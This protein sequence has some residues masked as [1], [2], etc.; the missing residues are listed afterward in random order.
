M[1]DPQRLLITGG[2][3]FIG[4]EMVRQYIRQTDATVVNLDKL[5]Y[6]DNLESLD[7]IADN[8][9][10]HFFHGDICDPAVV[11]GLFGQ[12]RPDAVIRLA[13]ESHVDRSI[14]GPSAFIQTN[15]VGTCNLL[16][17]A[18]GTGRV[19]RPAGRRPAVSCRSLRTRSTAA[20][21]KPGRSPK[22]LPMRPTRPTRPAKR[23]P[24]AWDTFPPMI[25]NGLPPRCR[26]TAS[27]SI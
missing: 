9:R 4:S 17:A 16:S 27:A 24:I 25:W 5:T 15:V 12:Y 8:P 19:R 23:S 2:A 1:P 10:Y 21:V 22:P 18:C 3:G 11:E 20:W 14:D 13:A 7:G 6:A 26:R